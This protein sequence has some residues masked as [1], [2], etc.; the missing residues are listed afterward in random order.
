[1]RYDLR[2][3]EAGFSV[4][5]ATVIEWHK[6]IGDYVHEG[7]TVVSIE[8]D[9]INVELPAPQSGILTEIRYQ[10]GEVV[11]VGDVLGVITSQDEAAVGSTTQ[12]LGSQ[13]AKAVQL[14]SG[15]ASREVLTA[16]ATKSPAT[17]AMT[18]SQRKISPVAKTLAKMEAVDLSQIETGSGP[19]G[20][21]VKEDV[22]RLI[23]EQKTAP[24]AVG[25]RTVAPPAEPEEKIHLTAWR[26]LIADRMTT[27]MRTIPHYAQSVEVDVTDL[28][29]FIASTKG[30]ADMPRMTY[31]P[32]V[33]K[34][35]Q[36]GLKVT[37]EANA[38]CDEDGYVM[39]KILNIGVAVDVSG[40]LL[41]P[42][43]RDVM[44]KTILELAEEIQVLIDKAR[45]NRLEPYDV[46][47]GT[48]TITNVGVFGLHSGWAIIL[49]PQTTIMAMGAVR[50]VPAVVNGSVV[51]RQKI[52]LTNSYDHRV[53]HGGPGG[54][55]LREIKNHL[56]NPQK[57]L[58]AMR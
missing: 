3:P 58:L 24:A 33:M 9:K 45:N 21:I 23:E 37:P 10:P 26:K 36:A 5:E 54:R 2:V 52:M 17:P 25:K 42:V 43:V 22:L 39:K 56:E 40:K 32:F 19:E 30:T 46:Q 34:A 4:P 7:E 44:G 38:Y 20:R 8:T 28:T 53:V 14:N 18:G 16:Q 47:D 13:D 15:A 50:E 48:F 41:V 57:L 1:M 12:A 6:E 55:F 51:I 49:P 11:A 31:L 29:E 35:I 27:S